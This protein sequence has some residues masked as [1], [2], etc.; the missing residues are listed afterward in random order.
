MEVIGYTQACV[1]LYEIVIS[2]NFYFNRNWIL[3]VLRSEEKIVQS[4]ENFTFIGKLSVT[5]LT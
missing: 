5:V 1:C 4:V 3:Q 2:L